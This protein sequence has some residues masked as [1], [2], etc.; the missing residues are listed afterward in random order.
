MLIVGGEHISYKNR[1]AWW[2]KCPDDSHWKAENT[3]C[4]E[5]GRVFMDDSTKERCT[6]LG[7][8]WLMLLLAGGLPL[9]LKYEKFFYF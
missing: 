5:T 7:K 4:G 1:M 8:S 3:K 6:L 2:F 9:S